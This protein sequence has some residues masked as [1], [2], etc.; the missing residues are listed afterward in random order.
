MSRL[1]LDG[2]VETVLRDQTLRRERGQGNINFPCSQLT[3]SRIGNLTRL[4]LTLAIR[5]TILTLLRRLAFP[6]L[7]KNTR[8][9]V[10]KSKKICN[11]KHFVILTPLDYN[12]KKKISERKA[13]TKGN[14]FKSL[15]RP[16]LLYAIRRSLRINIYVISCSKYY[17]TILSLVDPVL[18]Y[19][20]SHHSFGTTLWFTG[21]VPEDSRQ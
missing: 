13:R 18:A 16:L 5:I 4:I 7:K 10:G 12:R 19:L 2:T 15:Q 1:T 6:R 3:T 21:L 20:P 9:F 8:R 14:P 17:M 11:L